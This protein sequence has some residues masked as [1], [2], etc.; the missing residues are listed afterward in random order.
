MHHGQ[1]W[2]KV[3]AKRRSKYWASLLLLGLRYP[4]MNRAL[5]LSSR[6]GGGRSLPPYYRA[7]F[8][9]VDFLEFPNMGQWEKVLGPSLP[10]IEVGSMG[11]NI[12]EWGMA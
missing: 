2:F 6:I 1:P 4:V 10:D 9:L 8:L 11:L 5:M 3:H 12:E 7:Y